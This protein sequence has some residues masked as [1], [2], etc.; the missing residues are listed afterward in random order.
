VAQV[1]DL[2]SAIETL[3]PPQ[4]LPEYLVP[5]RTY[6]RTDSVDMINDAI[7]QLARFFAPAVLAAIRNRKESGNPHGAR[8]RRH[9]TRRR[10]P[11]S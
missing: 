1:D 4:R 6:L 5:S 7:E 2:Q 10:S 3:A 11:E 9:L 8:G